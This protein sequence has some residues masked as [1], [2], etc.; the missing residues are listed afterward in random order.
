[1]KYGLNITHYQFTTGSRKLKLFNV[2]A[3]LATTWFLVVYLS[4]YAK[5]FFLQP[6]LKVLVLIEYW[7]CGLSEI[8]DKVYLSL[9]TKFRSKLQQLMVCSNL[10]WY[11][12]YNIQFTELPTA[13]F[14]KKGTFTIS[15]ESPK[16]VKLKVTFLLHHGFPPNWIKVGRTCPFPLWFSLEEIQGVTKKLLSISP[17]WDFRH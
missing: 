9:L 14:M 15:D 8:L 5:I 11:Y 4:E 13:I 3:N 7:L 1:M 2:S 6:L 10:L 16:E 12:N 17:L